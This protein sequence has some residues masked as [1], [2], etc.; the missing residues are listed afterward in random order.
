M[1]KKNAL[2]SGMQPASTI[3]H[4]YSYDIWES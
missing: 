1:F 2:M 4:T 3:N